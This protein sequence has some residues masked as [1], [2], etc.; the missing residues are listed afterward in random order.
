MTQDYKNFLL[1]YLTNNLTEDV[2]NNVPSFSN[3]ISSD[4]SAYTTLSQQFTYGFYSNT[5]INTL[6]C[7]DSNGDYNGKT[8]YWGMYYT[9]QSQTQSKAFIAL[10]NEKM[11]ILEIITQFASG[12]DITAIQ[13]LNVDETGKIYGVGVIGN[14]T[15]ASFLM[16]NNISIKSPSSEH[17][18]AVLRQSY[19]LQGRVA[20]NSA[21]IDEIFK[22]VN[23]S[24]YYMSLDNGV[25]GGGT[26]LK[27][28]V[29]TQNEWQ[30][31][32][33]SVSSPSYSSVKFKTQPYWDTE[34]NITILEL[35]YFKKMNNTATQNIS[36]GINDENN[37]IQFT[38]IVNNI[39]DDMFNGADGVE[40][41]EQAY[42]G[43]RCDTGYILS[44]NHFYI[45]VPVS[46]YD[47][48][49]NQRNIY[50]KTIEYNN[51]TINDIYTFEYEYPVEPDEGKIMVVSEMYFI[52]NTLF[53]IDYICEDYTISNPF[54]T[55]YAVLLIDEDK[56]TYK[57]IAMMGYSQL[58]EFYI[59]DITNVYN[60][61]TINTILYN[62]DV[63]KYQ[64]IKV[65]LVYNMNNYNGEQYCDTNVLNPHQIWLYDDD[66][67][68]IFA[69]NLYNQTIYNNITE[70]TI[71]IPNTMLND[72]TISEQKLI[73]ETNYVLNDNQ[74]D[75]E[76]NIYETLYINF[77]NTLLIQNRNTQDYVSNII[78]SS[79]INRSVSDVND[80]DDA[81]ITKF[82]VN[83]KN[84]IS[85]VKNITSSTITNNIADI[86]FQLTIIS[87]ILNIEIISDDEITTYQTITDFTNYE[88]G[89]TYTLS[90]KC[91]VE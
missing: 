86:E 51:G 43:L 56:S 36:V 66:G 5:M 75:I 72:I 48:D 50:I 81:K 67:N 83:Y 55:V 7:K 34:G 9:N 84:G 71:E 52:N 74:E 47:S 31:Y 23:G 8:L 37:L 29:G 49:T 25:N 60:L 13:V 2:G 32:T 80:Y 20:T 28:N 18:K 42:S 82:R 44:T 33:S 4:S 58:N 14:N 17:Y 85:K 19:T 57:D 78:G 62:Y 22:D 63:S 12:T 59:V 77:F 39:T 64:Y 68:I 15:Y 91:Y 90:Q 53:N 65:N 30:D 46:I 26:S 87:D 1:D 70:S 11:E 40:I 35:R 88:I 21:S 89:H 69:R 10:L 41:L 27:I 3:N 79:R 38:T 24:N 76:K 6:K 61:Y 45:S 54:F 16:L 73:G